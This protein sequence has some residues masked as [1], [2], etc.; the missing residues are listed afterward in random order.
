[1]EN[2]KRYVQ[3]HN[4]LDP[5]YAENLEASYTDFKMNVMVQWAKKV[6]SVSAAEPLEKEKKHGRQQKS[7]RVTNKALVMNPEKE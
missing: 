6:V 7:S 4:E 3:K 2:V 5:A 1:M